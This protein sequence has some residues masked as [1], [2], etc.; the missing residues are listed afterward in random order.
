MLNQ[1]LLPSRFDLNK[2]FENSPARTGF[3]LLLKINPKVNE[4]LVEFFS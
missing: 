2:G 4:G 3:D 1:F